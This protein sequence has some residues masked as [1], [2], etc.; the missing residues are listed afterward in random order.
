MHALK[1][2]VR[3]EDPHI[4]RRQVIDA[5]RACVCENGF[6]ATKMSD[7]AKR[8]QLSVGLIY[9]HF[10]NKAALIEGIIADD[11]DRQIEWLERQ[12]AD[13]P[14]DV[15][16]YCQTFDTPEAGGLNMRLE[17]AA[18]LARNHALRDAIMGRQ[19]EAVR[20]VM[21]KMRSLLPNGGSDDA[22]ERLRLISALYIGVRL[23][24]AAEGSEGLERL[25]AMANAMCRD[26]ADQL[27]G[28]TG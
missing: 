20:L 24:I 26:Q 27:I 25:E 21:Q 19:R 5:A 17:I 2:R 9:Q 16:G 7:I 13:M 18:E 28:K 22:E 14:F 1:K 4:R 8:A 15:Y 12:P 11:L 3:V 23:Q 10:A 6:H